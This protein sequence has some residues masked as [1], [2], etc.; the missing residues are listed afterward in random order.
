MMKFQT[1]KLVCKAILS[2]TPIER[3]SAEFLLHQWLTIK[4]VLELN[5]LS[6]NAQHEK[7]LK[8]IATSCSTFVQFT[9]PRVVHLSAD[10]PDHF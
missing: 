7:T 4:T 9:Q 5:C 2:T 3:I 8:K 1:K 6:I 10:N